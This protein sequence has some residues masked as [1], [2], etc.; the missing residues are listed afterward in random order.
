M[1][2]RPRPGALESPAFPIAIKRLVGGGAAGHAPEPHWPACRRLVTEASRIGS[3]LLP[4]L[5]P[6][7]SAER[8]EWSPAH[9]DP[10][11]RNARTQAGPNYYSSASPYVGRLSEL[12]SPRRGAN[13]FYRAVFSVGKGQYEG[14]RRP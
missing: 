4:L 7:L 8:C 1:R 6:S 13:L 14:T 3:G 5:L 12:L 9:L 11:A 2:S 10:R